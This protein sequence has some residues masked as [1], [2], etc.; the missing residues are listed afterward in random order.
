MVGVDKISSK[1]SS[2]DFLL[3]ELAERFV[4]VFKPKFFMAG[5]APLD[6][7]R[8]ETEFFSEFSSEFSTEFRSLELNEKS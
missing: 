7:S 6:F 5:V 4:G 1:K 3:L 2:V 8:L